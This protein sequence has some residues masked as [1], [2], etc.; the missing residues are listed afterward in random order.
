MTLY[1]P[2][3]KV[4]AGLS[5]LLLAAC[6]TST[7]YVEAGA[8]STTTVPNAGRF[9]YYGYG[10]P[11]PYYGWGYRW[12]PFYRDYDLQERNR[13]TAMAYIRLGKGTKPTDLTTAYDA[14]LVVENLGPVITRPEAS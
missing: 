1:R 2:F 6:A 13:Y 8:G 12:D 7:P 10:R 3:A 11:F 9:S 4:L 14:R 5:V